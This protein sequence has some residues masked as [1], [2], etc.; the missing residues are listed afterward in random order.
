MSKST[1]CV[2][3]QIILRV[4]KSVENTYKDHGDNWQISQYP[5]ELL[6]HKIART[7]VDYKIAFIQS[8]NVV[9][10][11]NNYLKI[12][13]YWSIVKAFML[14]IQFKAITLTS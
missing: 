4:N 6:L 2:S 13:S 9:L 7:L 10:K 8:A 12:K 14:S 3:T 5:T 1:S 11:P